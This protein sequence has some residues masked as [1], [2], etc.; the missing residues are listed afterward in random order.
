MDFIFLALGGL[1]YIAVVTDIFRT[2]LSMHGGGW[3]TSPFSHGVWL[4]F[5]KLSGSNGRSRLL[6][7][8]GFLLLI[9]ILVLWIVGLW[10][11]FFLL[12]LSQSDS[13]VSSST[14]VPADAWEKFYYAGFTVSTLGI[15]DYIPSTNEWSVVT[16][17]Y[18]FTG[19]ALVTMSITY[20]VPVL[21]GVT[22]KRNLGIMISSFGQS[23]Q[24][25]VLNS[26]DGKS[27]NRMIAQAS[28]IANM[29]VMHSQ[30]H[31]AYPVIHYFHSHKAKNTVII[32]ITTLYEALLILRYYVKEEIRPDQNDLSPLHTALENYLEVISEVSTV[33]KKGSAPDLPDMTKLEEKGM[34]NPAL[35]DQSIKEEVQHQRTLLASL[36]EQDGWNWKEINGDR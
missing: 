22:Q 36:V 4:L 32:G 24:E 20:F 34:I 8:V 25:M 29:L 1:L 15:G 33:S 26:W 30:N 21:S 6:E 28:S 11:S 18:A 17:I 27:F 19:L 13:V 5:L 14:K 35:K 16:D 10:A 23:P 9:L 2:T 12:L 31:K 7:Q 3:F